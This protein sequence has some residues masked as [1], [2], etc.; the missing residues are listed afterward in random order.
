MLLIAI[1]HELHTLHFPVSILP[2][3]GTDEKEFIC[4]DVDWPQRTIKTRSPFSAPEHQFSNSILQNSVWTHPYT[5]T[6]TPFSNKDNKISASS[7]NCKWRW[8]NF[9]PSYMLFSF[10]TW[11]TVRH[12]RSFL[13]WRNYYLAGLENFSK[14]GYTFSASLVPTLSYLDM[15]TTIISC[16]IVVL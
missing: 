4:F 5:C 2:F 7:F 16:Q 11:L 14:I 15:C 6:Y 12:Q 1:S 10:A 8:H 13:Y 3:D 9:K